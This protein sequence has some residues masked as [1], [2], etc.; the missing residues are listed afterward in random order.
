M[1]YGVYFLFEWNNPAFALQN[2]GGFLCLHVG[3][4]L[5]DHVLMSFNGLQDNGKALFDNEALLSTASDWL[6]KSTDYLCIYVYK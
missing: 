5:L 4:R 1:P 3:K 6:Y 2:R